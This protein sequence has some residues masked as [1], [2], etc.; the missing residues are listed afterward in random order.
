M[1]FLGI[2]PDDSI[3]LETDSDEVVFGVLEGTDRYFNIK[4]TGPNNATLTKVILKPGV[5]A[6]APAEEIVEIIA[7]G[8]T[9]IL[10]SVEVDK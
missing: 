5:R 10:G 6:D 1:A 9:T 3:F 8:D 2:R 7:T 4:I